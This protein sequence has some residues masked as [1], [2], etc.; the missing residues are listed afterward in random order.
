MHSQDRVKK[1][2]EAN[3]MGFGDEAKEAAIAIKAPGS[4]LLNDLKARFIV[5]IEQFIGD[6]ASSGFVG[7][8]YRIGA[9]PL[10]ANDGD[11]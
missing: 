8:F 10:D 2:G 11:K 9:E 5:A 6:F 3:A 7:E 4:T 1:M